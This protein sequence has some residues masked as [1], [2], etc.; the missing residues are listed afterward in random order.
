MKCKGQMEMIGFVVIVILVTLGMLFISQFAFG[1]GPTKKIAKG[2]ERA[3]TAMMAL[4]K[5]STDCQA[6]NYEEDYDPMPTIGGNLIDDCALSTE[7]GSTY[8]C[9]GFDNSCDFLRETI[10]ELLKETFGM[11][12]N[13]YEFH[14]YLMGSGDKEG[15][16]FAVIKD[17][18][19]RGEEVG[20]P[21]E[22]YST[23]QPISTDKGLVRNVLYLCD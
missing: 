4:M 1:E 16:L 5:T 22:R 21:R 10:S 17:V 11:W 13:H 2:E 18:N 15:E 14:A 8:Q 6:P 19:E 12:K 3:A 20:C 23:E 7:F 9:D